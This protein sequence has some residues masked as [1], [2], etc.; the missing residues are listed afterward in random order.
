MWA[1]H[2]KILDPIYFNEITV[3]VLA[4]QDAN[5][6]ALAKRNPRWSG[7]MLNLVHFWHVIRLKA[8]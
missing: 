8:H 3:P 7:K 1:L 5:A 4:Q 6:E 2:E